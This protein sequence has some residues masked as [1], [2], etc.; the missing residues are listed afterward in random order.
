MKGWRLIL[1]KVRGSDTVVSEEVTL[2][3]YR[4]DTRENLGEEFAQQTN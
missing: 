4:A 1:S 3:K 2:Y